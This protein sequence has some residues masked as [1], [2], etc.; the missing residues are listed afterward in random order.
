MTAPDL[1]ARPPRRWNVAV[2][3]VIWL[4]RMADKAR[5]YLAGTLGMYL[6]GQSPIDDAFLRSA[7]LD[8]EQFLQIVRESPD[9]AAVLAGIEKLS[10]G[11]TERLRAF[12]ER[13]PRRGRLLLRFIDFD[14]GHGP[15]WARVVLP[16]CRG[17]SALIALTLRA[18]RPAPVKESA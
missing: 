2:D 11:A 10:P 4:P 6:Y 17:V 9:D 14:D 8:Y 15:P 3:G 12:S 13:L 7:R 1:R 5:A 18:R 16:A